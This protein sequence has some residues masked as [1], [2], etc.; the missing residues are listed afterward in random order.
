MKA[1][2]VRKIG[3][4]SNPEDIDLVAMKKKFRVL[5]DGKNCGELEMDEEEFYFFNS[6]VASGVLN[7]FDRE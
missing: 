6:I 4:E 5:L 3:F 1:G 2:R 7:A